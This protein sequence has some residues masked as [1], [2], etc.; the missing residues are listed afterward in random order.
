[1]ASEEYKELTE[2]LARLESLLLAGTKEVL[3]MDECSAFTGYS[4]NHLYRMTSQRAIPFYKP[5]GGTIYFKK[6]ELEEWLLRNRQSTE[7]EIE[8]MATTYCRTH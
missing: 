3:T 7:D 1:M 4:K 2:R 6:K 5:M 8:R